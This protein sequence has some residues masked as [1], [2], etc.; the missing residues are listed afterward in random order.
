MGNHVNKLSGLKFGRLYV[1]KDSGKRTN[2]GGILWECLCDCGNSCL[3]VSHSI[4]SGMVKSCG[5]LQKEV[6]KTHGFSY[7]R[8][9]RIWQSMKTR[10]YFEG[11]SSYKHYGGRGIVMC[12]KWNAFE[13]FYS[14]MGE[15]PSE[16]HQIDRID[17]NLGY[18]KDNCRW[19]TATVNMQNRRKRKNMSSNYIGVSRDKSRNKFTAQCNMKGVKLQKRFETEIEAA[20]AYNVFALHLYGKDA[21]VNKI[22]LPPK[23]VERLLKLMEGE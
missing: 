1:I 20:I 7:T 13:G 22:T 9:H 6:L 23:E 12:E 14:E 11:H 19:V 3:K 21:R 4:K 17:N 8:I 10:C 15:P 18:F 16:K 5:C 2:K